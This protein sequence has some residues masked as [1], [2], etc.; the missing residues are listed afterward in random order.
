MRAAGSDDALRLENPKKL[1]LEEA[2]EFIAD[3][4]ILEVTPKNIR[5][6]KAV[7]DAEQ[8]MKLRARALK[9]VSED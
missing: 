9:N 4:E 7:L 6:R 2:M 1:S 5:L 3:D 8:R